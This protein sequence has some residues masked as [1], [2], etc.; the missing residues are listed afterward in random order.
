MNRLRGLLIVIKR[1]VYEL[2]GKSEKF[3]RT[4]KR[5]V[6]ARL[7]EREREK[8]YRKQTTID[9][10][11]VKENIRNI[12]A[13]FISHDN[14]GGTRAYE[15][16]FVREHNNL[17][18]F[19]RMRYEFMEDNFFQIEFYKDGK[20]L[21]APWL[22]KSN[23]IGWVFESEYNEIMVNSLVTYRNF[24]DIL[25]ELISYKRKYPNCTI[26]YFVHDFH[27]VCPNLNLFTNSQYCEL[28]CGIHKC[29][30][31]IGDKKINIYDW[32][33]KWL[34]FLMIADEVRC[35]SESSK[36]IFK[37]AYPSI[38]YEK[39][40]VVPHD[41]SYCKKNP[42]VDVESKPLCIGIVGNVAS[43]PKG[44]QIVQCILRNFGQ[45]IPI[46]MIGTQGW[47][48]GVFKKNI[49]YLG[50]YKR[51][52]LREILI[53]EKVSHVIFPSLCPETFSYLISELIAFEI[54]IICFDCGAQAEKVKKY[55]KGIVCK[56]REEMVGIIE[57]L[58]DTV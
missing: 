40:K 53:R 24:S 8:K 45:S 11:R 30:L 37:L 22:L 34:S 27:G 2:K 57:K 42:I 49:K 15:K 23:D 46:R 16:S 20:L 39:F 47:K 9:E 28:D 48:F 41:M 51:E 29:S 21:E 1:K 13:L 18:I 52:E 19:R 44:K 26:K 14:E 56:N 25:E 35:F 32:R 17:V 10:N 50:P 55:N 3:F 43:E 7:I 5:Y 12:N 58:V 38:S 33:N 31:F 4:M 36:E 54:P 6:Q